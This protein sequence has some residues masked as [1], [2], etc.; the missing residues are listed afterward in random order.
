MLDYDFS[1]D[2]DPVA[3]EFFKVDPNISNESEA[4]SP[5]G[6]VVLGEMERMKMPSPSL[7]QKVRT[8]L[9]QCHLY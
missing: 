7:S 6:R 1:E 4:G 5:S 9:V 3:A 2:G 8:H